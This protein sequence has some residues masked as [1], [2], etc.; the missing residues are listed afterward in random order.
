MVLEYSENTR[1]AQ[2]TL[3]NVKRAILMLQEWNEGVE[4]ADEWLTS[5]SGMQKLAGNAMMIEVIGE[6][7]KKVEKRLGTEFLNQRPEIPWRDVMGMRNHIAHGYFDINELYVFSVIKND[8]APLLEA[9]DHL[10][11]VLDILR[12]EQEVDEH[13]DNYQNPIVS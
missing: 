13:F 3:L 7:I 1:L 10:I 8:L 9:I 5:T 11:S 4:S 12:I 2:E 6:E